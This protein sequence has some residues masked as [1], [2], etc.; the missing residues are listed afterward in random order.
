MKSANM[1]SCGSQRREAGGFLPHNNFSVTVAGCHSPVAGSSGS[2]SGPGLDAPFFLC[3]IAQRKSDG[4]TSRR[5][6]VRFRFPRFSFIFSCVILLGRGSC[7]G[8]GLS[9]LSTYCG[10]SVDKYKILIGGE[11]DGI[12]T[13]AEI[14]CR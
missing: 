4:L 9:F 7:F 8:G 13:K 10:S 11:S 6:L 14:I 3:G 2:G 12:D 1:L 5:S